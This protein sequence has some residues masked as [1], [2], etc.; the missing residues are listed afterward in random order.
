MNMKPVLI[1]LSFTLA[2]LLLHGQDKKEVI[3]KGIQ[4]KRNYE[5]DIANGE[6]EASLEKEEY[7]NFRGDLVEIKE[8]DNS[9]K[10]I[11]SWFKYKYDNQGE[12]IEELELNAKGEQKERAEYKYENGLKTEKLIYDSKNR[13]SKKKTFKY[14]LRK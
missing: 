5:T 12:L 14:E 3:E 9:G 7:Y 4:V 10:G 1:T 2:T 11:T 13:L 6:K 8:Y